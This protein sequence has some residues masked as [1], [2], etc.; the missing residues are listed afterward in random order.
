MDLIFPLKFVFITTGYSSAHPAIDIGWCDEYGGPH[1]PIYAP[2]DGVVSCIQDGYGTDSSKGYGN[3]IQIDHGG[4]LSTIMAH[5]NR[6]GFTVRQGD[7][8][9]RGQPVAHMGNSGNT[10]GYHTHTCVLVNGTRVN[11]LLYY[12]LDTK[13]QVV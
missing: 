8:V 1:S 2:A 7:R 4:G 12:H 5:C 10:A 13:W 3:Y 11:P 9:A 6:G